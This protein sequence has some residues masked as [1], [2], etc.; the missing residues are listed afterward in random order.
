MALRTPLLLMTARSSSE[1]PAGEGRWAYEPKFDGF[2]CLAFRRPG[3]RST[4]QSRQ[5]RPLTRFFPEVVAALQEQLHLGVV[6]DGEL[7]ICV[8]GRLDFAALQGRLS[9]ARPSSFRASPD[10]TKQRNKQ[11]SAWGS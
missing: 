9:G 8:D 11:T 2:R 3:G 1:L 10:T 5:Q 4:L 6:L 7:V